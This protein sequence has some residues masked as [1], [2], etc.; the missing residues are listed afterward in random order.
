M[1]RGPEY[2][3][4]IE[5]AFDTNDDLNV[6]VE[7]EQTNVPDR[8]DSVDCV[9]SAY[10]LS[11]SHGLALLETVRD[12]DPEIPFV[13][14]TTVPFEDVGESLLTT[15]GTD[16]LEKAWSEPRMALLERRIRALVVGSHL[17]TAFR[18]SAAALESSREATLIVSSD[19]TV[20]FANSRLVAELTADRAAIQGEHWTQ[21]FTDE[22]AGTLRSEA[23]PV[24]ADGWEWTGTTALQTLNG[25]N[26]CCRTSLTGL[27]DGSLVFVFHGLNHIDSS[28]GEAG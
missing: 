1:K 10:E 5:T 12:I 21:L 24:A 15:E 27:D 7:T 19:G 8:L 17:D 26:D 13:L 28:S 16:Y 4:L 3:A 23:I 6:L 11:E 14:H 25:A 2:L 20:A 18:Q 9:V 22:S